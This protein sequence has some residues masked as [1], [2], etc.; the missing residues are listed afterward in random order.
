MTLQTKGIGPTHICPVLIFSHCWL[1]LFNQTVK[2]LLFV[3]L[4]RQFVLA[5]LQE[6]LMYPA[7]KKEEKVTEKGKKSWHLY[8]GA[9][10]GFV[11]DTL[12]TETGTEVVLGWGWGGQFD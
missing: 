3:K 5:W 7:I 10:E 2:A 8:E 4:A 11:T 12:K 1:L 6:Q 9:A